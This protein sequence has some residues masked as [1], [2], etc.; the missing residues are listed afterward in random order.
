MKKLICLL[1][2]CGG[3]MACNNGS[4]DSKDVKDSVLNKI[5]STKDAKIDSLKDT[6]QK[7]KEKVENSFDK[8]DSA[9]RANAKKD[10]T[11]HK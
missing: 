7:L 11:L 4:N 5:D 3:L 2:L 10:S 1:V 8:T 9:N 6:A